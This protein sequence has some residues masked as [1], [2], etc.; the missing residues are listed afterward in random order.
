MVKKADINVRYRVSL[1]DFESKLKTFEKKF[2]R[3][4]KKMKRLGKSLSRSLSLPIVGLGALATR[5]FAQYEQA[6]A[7]V[8]AISGATGTELKTLT[9]LSKKLGRTTRFTASQVA[10]LELVYSKLGFSVREIENVTEATLN[11]ALATGE[12]LTESAKVAGA[13]LRGFNLD[14]SEMTRVVDVMAKSFASS[15]LD[16]E[17][18]KVS[19][20]KIAPVANAAGVSLE[21][22]A[23]LQGVLA[24][25]GV[26][27][28]VIGTSLRKIF[29]TLAKSGLSYEQA[30][31]KI[32]NAT[33]K[34]KTAQEIF[35]QRAF[36]SA[37]ILDD[38][39]Q[40]V[41]DLARANE[42]AFGTTK[43]LAAI[44]DDTLLGSLLKVKSAI[45]GLAIEFG[46]ALKPAVEKIAQI[47]VKITNKFSGLNDT[48]KRFI[49]VVAGV[50]AV[51]GPLIFVIGALSTGLAIA[52]ANVIAF[53][54]ALV[55]NPLGLA[56]VGI[57][58]LTAALVGFN[59]IMG[60]STSQVNKNTK[61][62]DAAMSIREETI[63]LMAKEKAQL[64]L[65]L[66][67][68]RSDTASR[69]DRLRAVKEINKISPEFLSNITLEKI[70]TEET[71]KAVNAYTAALT[72]NAKALAT[73]NLLA[74][75]E[76]EI[77]KTQIAI[78]A[79]EEERFKKTLERQKELDKGFVVD[80]G[81]AKLKIVAGQFVLVGSEAD[82][83]SQKLV[84]LQKEA[85]D[86]KKFGVIIPPSVKGKIDTTGGLDE[87]GKKLASKRDKA[88]LELKTRSIRK[89]I[90]E[91]QKLRDAKEAT[92]FVEVAANK[93]IRAKKIEI[94]KLERDAQ[95]KLSESDAERL[96]NQ[97][98]FLDNVKKINTEL[99]KVQINE[100]DFLPDPVATTTFFDFIIAKLDQL[101][102]KFASVFDGAFAVTSAFFAKDNAMIDNNHQKRIDA[103]NSS[104]NT[105]QQKAKAIEALDEETNKKR[106]ALARKQAIAQKAE[107]I[108]SGTLSGIQATLR[109]LAIGGPILAGIISALA[110]T[111]VALIAATP[112]PALAE[113]GLAFGPTQALV[114]DN[115][116]S[117]MDPEVIAPLSKI[118]AMFG[119]AP[120]GLST[121]LTGNDIFISQ[122]LQ[123]EDNA[124]FR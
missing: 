83:L 3:T 80:R 40:K 63:K 81:V 76:E 110:A 93:L 73:R 95:N 16:L 97:V 61:A 78:G 105:E 38:N 31:D 52:T 34:V 118:R 106:R 10:E 89:E 111:Q 6:M 18:F 30:L 108:F 64:K 116:N 102:K 103:I 43:K 57:S 92:F 29:V 35:G 70:N 51:I 25:S 8:Q 69:E 90:E 54:T 112:L 62:F 75:K 59:F 79:A 4:G 71:T 19:M 60:K 42:L 66:D 37:I 13:T 55:T 96:L 121:V 21:R 46:E 33:D 87:A 23:A 115:K 11:L 15:A 53:S 117:R 28:S 100:A 122:K 7:K 58:T 36:V 114:G 48:W 86:I 26:E 85:E 5:E 47:V 44:M 74:K 120:G 109:G 65:L 101:G 104:T 67:V 24:D 1:K 124:R 39:R 119:N 98:K 22:A 113:G 45:E 2:I 123:G 56:L 49:L 9:D 77:L 14:A 17:K 68:A 107:A 27:A 20:G 99:Q 84:R 41:E 32:R 88:L 50:A 82:E 12:D 94:F 72:K 91:L